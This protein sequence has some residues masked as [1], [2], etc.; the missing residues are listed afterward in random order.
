MPTITLFVAERHASKITDAIAKFHEKPGDHTFREL[1]TAVATWLAMHGTQKPMPWDEQQ[2]LTLTVEPIQ[3]PDPEILK[4][5][6]SERL[7]SA[8]ILPKVPSYTGGTNG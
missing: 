8:G 4:P 7:A 2:L 6:I 5:S 3:K 1:S